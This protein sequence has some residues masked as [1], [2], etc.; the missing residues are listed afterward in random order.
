M[1]PAQQIWLDWLIWWL[2][3][4]ESNMSHF[5]LKPSWENIQLVNHVFFKKKNI[6]TQLILSERN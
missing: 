1:D 3:N 4:L 2:I 5:F 6:K